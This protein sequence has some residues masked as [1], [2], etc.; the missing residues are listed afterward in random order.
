MRTTPLPSSA[1]NQSA[2]CPLSERELLPCANARWCES[3][4]YDGYASTV[5][6]SPSEVPAWITVGEPKLSAPVTGSSATSPAELS[7]PHPTTF[8][9]YAIACP[10]GAQFG[11][12]D[13][14]AGSA[15]ED[16]EITA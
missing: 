6:R 13:A 15:P 9:R 10:S 7:P 1:M 4:A 5:P 3:G 2:D 8:A 16:G 11:C 12:V 14:D